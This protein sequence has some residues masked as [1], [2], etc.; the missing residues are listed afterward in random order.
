MVVLALSSCA[1]R[2]CSPVIQNSVLR[3]DRTPPVDQ[4]Q[5]VIDVGH[6]VMIYIVMADIE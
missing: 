1:T 2:R 3:T 5:Q 4:Q 6:S